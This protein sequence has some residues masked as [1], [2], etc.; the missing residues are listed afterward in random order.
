MKI[1]MTCL[2]AAGLWTTAGSF[3]CCA[4]A[5]ETDGPA[6]KTPATERTSKLK[7]NAAAEAVQ[8]LTGSWTIVSGVNQ[9]R[10]VAADSLQGS[11]VLFGEN[12]VVVLDAEQ[13]ELYKAAY[14][15]SGDKPPFKIDMTTE[16]PN[17][18]PTQGPGLV[19]FHDA[20]LRL[21]YALPGGQRP[22]KFESGPG[23][24]L[25][26]F[27]MNRID[28]TGNRPMPQADTTSQTQI[29]DVLISSNHLVGANIVDRQ[30][31]TLGKIDELVIS[32][33]GRWAHAV[34]KIG[35]LLGVGGSAVAIP[36]PVIRTENASENDSSQKNTSWLIVDADVQRA[37]QL[38]TGERLE[39]TDAGWLQS[40]LDYFGVE[41]SAA[42]ANQLS[43]AQAANTIAVDK[44]INSEVFGSSG[45]SLAYLDA[46]ILRLHGQPSVPFAI[47]GYGGVLGVGKDFVAI[48]FS[49]LQLQPAGNGKYRLVVALD[50]SQLAAQQKVTPEAYPE[51]RLQSVLQRVGE[52]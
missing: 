25:M 11:R 3:D 38:E 37:P 42:T 29:S 12:T 34:V 19:E 50:P 43:E 45:E 49:K 5:Q 7:P 4:I 39:L 23:S 48:D 40:N 6:A 1:Y 18:E 15:L 27:E 28:S 30:H 41:R 9:G 31:K 20:G 47:L 13:N 16:L 32:R 21:C 17:Q 51:L 35:S 52:P 14:K 44:L 22:T 10:A 33:D 36:L 46:L 8:Q 24:K 2:L 26:L